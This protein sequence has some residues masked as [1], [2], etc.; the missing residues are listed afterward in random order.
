MSIGRELAQEACIEYWIQD[1]ETRDRIEKGNWKTK[2]G[3]YINI[4][5]MTDS[6]I[7]NCII[8]L[9]K[10][11]VIF[12]YSELWIRRFEKEL[13]FRNYIKKIMSGELD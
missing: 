1:W 2:D 6:Y 13:E 8:Y 12:E 3:A 9:S 11:S 4:K 7:N 5:D 10:Q